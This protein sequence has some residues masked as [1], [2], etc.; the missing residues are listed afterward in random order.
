MD[1]NTYIKLEY[2]ELL[3]IATGIYSKTKLDP[4]EVLSEL[5]LDV[6]KRN[7]RPYRNDYRYYCI[8][9]LKNA[10]RWQGG[11]PVKKLYIYDKVNEKYKALQIEAINSL[12]VR[13]SEIVKDLQRIGFTEDQA[14]RLEKCIKASKTLPLY[15]RR[16]FELYYLENY[17]LQEIADSITITDNRNGP[18]TIPKVAIHRDVKRVVE[19]IEK[20]INITECTI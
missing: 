19:E 2:D 15:Y 13:G 3:Q 18:R 14:E 9:W 16:L 5:Y 1:F 6:R 7:I 11:N 20:R 10:T 8:R 17:S 4:A 12:E